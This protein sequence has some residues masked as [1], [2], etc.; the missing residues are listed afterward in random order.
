MCWLGRWERL[1]HLKDEKGRELQGTADVKSF[2][3]SCQDARTLLQEK[4]AQLE[5]TELGSTSPSLEAERRRQGHAEREIQAL[6]RRI[7]YLKGIA[8]MWVHRHCPH[9]SLL[10]L[11]AS[12]LKTLL[13]QIQ[14]IFTGMTC[15]TCK[16]CQR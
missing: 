3:Q 15:K 5:G 7:E 14:V 12:L 11:P 13:S 8:K 4:L 16:H 6:E 10:A 2:L 1:Q 9:C